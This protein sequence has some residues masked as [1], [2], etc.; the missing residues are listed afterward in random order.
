[1]SNTTELMQYHDGTNTG[2]PLWTFMEHWVLETRHETR[3]P[4]GLSYY[5][6]ASRTRH[7]YTDA[8]NNMYFNNSCALSFY[9]V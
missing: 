1:M 2:V 5:C 6:L 3:C 9:L 4:E 8:A 7:Q